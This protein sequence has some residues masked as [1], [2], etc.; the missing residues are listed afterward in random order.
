MDQPQINR[1]LHNAIRLHQAGKFADAEQI[2]REILNESP[3]DSDALQMLGMLCLQS[4]R[5]GEALT[6]LRKSVEL[7]PAA[8]D[9][10]YHLGLALLE[11][12]KLDLAITSFSRAIALQPDFTEAYNNLGIALKKSGKPL[13]AINI[14]RKAP[15]KPPAEL[16]NNLANAL[17][18]IGDAD[19][20]IAEFRRAIAL[21]PSPVFH[22]NLLLAMHYSDKINPDEIFRE[23]LEW[24]RRYA[25]PG[26]PRII[27]PQ[28][29]PDKNRKLRIGYVSPDFRAHSVAY[30]LQNVLNDRDAELFE[31][32]AYS[33]AAEEDEITAT[34]RGQ[35][36]HWQTIAGKSH[37]IVAELIRA[38]EIDILID[39]A[40]HTEGN[41]LMVFAEKPAKVQI[42][43]LG[44]PDTTGLGAMD[45]RVTDALA[46]PPTIS[47]RLATEKLI[48]LPGCFLSY[49][50]PTNAPDVSPSPAARSGR[51]TFGSFNSLAKL[52]DTAITLWANILKAVPTSRLIIK[53]ETGLQEPLSRDRLLGKFTAAQIDPARLEISGAV[54]TLREHL[55]FYSRVDI[56]LDSYPYHGTTTTCE[57]LW[58]GVP[59][60]SLAG[61]THASRAGVS[62]LTN[63][64]YPDWIARSPDEY[65]QI[66]ATLAA[67]LH[68][69]PELRKSLRRKLTQSAIFNGQQFARNLEKVYRDIS[70]SQD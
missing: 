51:V 41:R 25:P 19:I 66:A 48:R 35:V 68:Q 46:D 18:V 23:H 16:L 6:L 29:D 32:F 3:A 20:A 67:D 12:G 60:I 39:L 40:G 59:V 8:P 45:Y 69:L 22:S 38:D 63:L 31:I 2:Y 64:G 56:A 33:D 24:N 30:F 47:D 54:P 43:Y 13:E 53:S 27:P 10:H 52:S 42:T 17:L 44:Y 70:R 15:G 58:M 50:P 37:A 49:C 55:D 21:Q 28:T 9:G 1:R 57:S 14:Y 62:L 34:I 5:K 11:S 61:Q 36:D 65:V 26:K 4:Q 7:N